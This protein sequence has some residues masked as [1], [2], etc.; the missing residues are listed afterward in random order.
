M[1]NLNKNKALREAI[2]ALVYRVLKE[3]E[4]ETTAKEEPVAQPEPEEQELGGDFQNAV[5]LFIRKTSQSQDTVTVD[6]LTD[7]LSQIIDRFT[8]TSEE[9]LNLLKGVRNN[10]IR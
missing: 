2:R 10:V 5:D 8:T 1:K 4:E 7:M 6:D 9:R 3:G